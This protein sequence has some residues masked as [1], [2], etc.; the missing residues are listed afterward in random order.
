MKKRT[1]FLM[2][3]VILMFI[4]IIIPYIQNASAGPSTSGIS[5]FM[6]YYVQDFP[7]V[8]LYVISMGM[9]EGVLLTLFV[10]SLLIDMK[11][12][13]PTKFDLNP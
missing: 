4:A 5:F 13:E 7:P 8:Y 2:R 12:D 11:G 6:G 3:F 1:M 10:Q 9:I